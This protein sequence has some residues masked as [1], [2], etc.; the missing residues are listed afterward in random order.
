MDHPVN[1]AQITCI[2]SHLQLELLQCIFIED[3]WIT[4]QSSIDA[5]H[6]VKPT[7]RSSTMHIYIYRRHMDPQSIEHRCFAYH[8]THCLV[9]L[10]SLY[11]EV[12]M[13]PPVKQAEMPCMPLHPL[14]R[15]S[16]MHIYIYRRQMDPPVNQAEMPCI[17]LHPLLDLDTQV[18]WAQNALHSSTPTARSS[19]IH[20]YRK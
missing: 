20:I 9:L 12:Q 5:L 14:T 7:A 15:P 6:T 4:H 13:V 3:R 10:Q 17:S 2:P 1:W 18:N 16:T 19:K 8:Y 11:I